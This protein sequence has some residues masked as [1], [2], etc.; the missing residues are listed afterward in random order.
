MLVANVEFKPRVIQ[1]DII[2]AIVQ[3]V[4]PPVIRIC[5]CFFLFII[6]LLILLKMPATN[7]LYLKII[8]HNLKFQSHI[9]NIVF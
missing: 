1:N 5:L 8:D 7:V 6:S 4:V 9:D 3:L 2:L